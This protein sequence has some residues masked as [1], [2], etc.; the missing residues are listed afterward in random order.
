MSGKLTVSVAGA[1]DVGPV[2]SNNEDSYGYDTKAGVFVVSD[3]MGGAQ[4]GEVASR[5]AVLTVAE[6]MATKAAD[7]VGGGQWAK[8][9]P[10]GRTLAHAIRSANQAI[11]TGSQ[12]KPQCAGM[13]ATIVAVVVRDDIITVGHVGDS[14]VY[15]VR[16]GNI[17]QLTQ[18]HSL[19]AEQVRAGY[20]TAEEAEE[21]Q[22]QNV[23]T[24]AL[25]PEEEVDADIQELEAKPGDT[26]LL[27]CD[28]I[29]KPVGGGEIL[30][31]VT[32]SPTLQEGCKRLIKAAVD[33]GGDDNLTCILLRV[34]PKSLV[35]AF[36]GRQVRMPQ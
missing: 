20:M 9:S 28:G 6:Q 29:T 8:L 1:T 27:A 36:R 21:S 13:G 26:L 19:V 22:L 23:I 32:N 16:D 30:Q 7:S 5:L 34:E 3:G 11:Y 35:S 12:S 25:G 17:E 33:N 2:R 31:I 24:R 18:D 15:L 14:R 4:A 10:Q